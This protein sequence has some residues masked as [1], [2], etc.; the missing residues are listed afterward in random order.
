[1]ADQTQLDL[2]YLSY[3]L[4]LAATV[5][6][7]KRKRVGACLVGY[8]SEGIPH[9]IS[10]GVNGRDPGDNRPLEGEQG[11]T[12]DDTRHAEKNCF[13]KLADK[14]LANGATLYVTHQPCKDCAEIAIAHGVS[15]VVYCFPYKCL[16]GL[17]AL[18]QAGI[19]YTLLAFCGTAVQN[20]LR[21]AAWRSREYYDLSG[22]LREVEGKTEDEIND[23]IRRM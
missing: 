10:D 9:L 6:K 22:Y 13:K 2:L 8:S 7:G 18:K 5:S 14:S 19:P 11:S 1:M 15:R 12:V 3:A 23:Y 16:A 21:Q 4:N 17:A 20:F